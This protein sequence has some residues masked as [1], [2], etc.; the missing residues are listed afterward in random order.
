MI[1]LASF[2]SSLCLIYQM[3]WP[4][5]F[6]AAK[7]LTCRIK[8]PDG[9]LQG[10]NDVTY[11]TENNLC[12]NGSLTERMSG[13]HYQDC[14]VTNLMEGTGRTF[15][16]D[17]KQCCGNDLISRVNKD[18]RRIECC[19]GKMPYLVEDGGLCCNG[20]Y[21]PNAGANMRC[22]GGIKFNAANKIC[23]NG[24]IH[25][26]IK[27]QLQSCCGLK[28]FNPETHECYHIGQHGHVQLRYSRKCGGIPYDSR[29]KACCQEKLYDDANEQTSFGCCGP[30]LRRSKYQQ[31]CNDTIVHENKQCCGYG[32]NA[33]EYDDQ[34]HKCEGGKL[35]LKSN[36]M[37][38][39]GPDKQEYDSN[40]Q[41]CCGGTVLSKRD[42]CCAGQRLPKDHICCQKDSTYEAEE[43]AIKKDGAHDNKCCIFYGGIR[44]SYSDIKMRCVMGEVRSK[45]L[46]LCGGKPYNKTQDLCCKGSVLYPGKKALNWKC[47]ISSIK[48][49]H[50]N[51]DNPILSIQMSRQMCKGNKTATASQRDIAEINL[52]T[53]PDPVGSRTK[54]W[55]ASLGFTFL[56]LFLI[57]L[58]PS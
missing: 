54:Q 43:K 8:N 32:R 40:N 42:K 1:Q 7:E 29:E 57:L 49:Y 36:P 19:D 3:F 53:Q 28:S 47:C 51:T 10:H 52:Q 30:N 9:S 46:Q 44:N 35:L 20:E 38:F 14:C 5:A 15:F 37:A 27:G 17:E 2:L 24:H 12:C 25:K 6:V 55:Q 48:A 22:C 23:C 50:I 13:G 31:C 45:D 21:D 41:H 34:V 56:G 11:D 16:I 39:C 4:P 33:K 58:M 26:R 18:G